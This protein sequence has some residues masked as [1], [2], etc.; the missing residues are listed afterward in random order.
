MITSAANAKIKQVIQWQSKLKERRRDN[1]Y[2]VEGFKMFEEAPV[3]Q[4][5]EVYLSEEAEQR[6]REK[7]ELS[8]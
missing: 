6:A 4:I 5:K 8:E 7:K 1:V 2:V 3:E